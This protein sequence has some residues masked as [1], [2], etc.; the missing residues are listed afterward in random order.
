[1]SALPYLTSDPVLVLNGDSF[2]AA[3]LRAFWHWHNERKAQASMLLTQVEESG[4]YGTVTVNEQAQVVEFAEKAKEG[5]PNWINGGVY[6]LSRSVVLSICDN[7]KSS[8][9]YDVFSRLVGRGLYGRITDAGFFDIGTP[10][11]YAAAVAFFKLMS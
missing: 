9:E 7:V 1:R 3:D 4:R 5:G 11:D 10:E 2:L 8:L 6:L